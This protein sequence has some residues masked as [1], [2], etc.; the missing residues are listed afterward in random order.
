M[1][2]TVLEQAEDIE[3]A[4]AIIRQTAQSRSLQFVPQPSPFRPRVLRG[5]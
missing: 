3:A 4:V 5:I 1:V 2:K